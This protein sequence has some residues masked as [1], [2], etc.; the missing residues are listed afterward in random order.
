MRVRPAF[1]LCVPFFILLLFL[2]NVDTG[3]HS[4]SGEGISTEILPG[5]DG[6]G[7]ETEILPN[8]DEGTETEILPNNDEETET[9][10]LPNY[11]GS[12]ML[13][14]LGE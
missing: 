6:S 12:G 10:I 9:E 3:I 7:I 2:D 14:M 4:N 1:W 11:E 13:E 8:T 5:D